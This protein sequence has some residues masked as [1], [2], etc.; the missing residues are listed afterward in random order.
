MHIKIL[1]IGSNESSQ[2]FTQSLHAEVIFT[3]SAWS[4]NML[5]T[6]TYK[7]RLGNDDIEIMR[8]EDH[9]LPLSNLKSYS[10]DASGFI[11]LAANQQAADAFIAAL[12]KGAPLA[13]HVGDGEIN[14]MNG[15][16]AVVT[17]CHA[18]QKKLS[19][20]PN[21]QFAKKPV[22]KKTEAPAQSINFE[23]MKKFLDA[24]PKR[25]LH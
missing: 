3:Q 10:E 23:L 17:K 6:G 1:L 24:T 15:V 16:K 12:P 21:A 18:R 25:R 14:A 19:S 2:L 11:Y 13:I 9:Q 20:N 8:I 4:L 7:F 22:D 5:G